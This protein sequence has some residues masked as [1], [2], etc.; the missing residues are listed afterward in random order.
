LTEA[1]L[2]D[3]QAEGRSI[4]MVVDQAILLRSSDGGPSRHLVT[5]GYD[6]LLV[7]VQAEIARSQTEGHGFEAC[8]K[9]GFVYLIS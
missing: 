8:H 9:P 4:R 3:T 5:K 1:G 7:Q 2:L 6:Q